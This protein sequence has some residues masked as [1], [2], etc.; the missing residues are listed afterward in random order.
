[1]F[2]VAHKDIYRVS[3]TVKCQN[4]IIFLVN[5]NK[6]HPR[7]FFPHHVFHLDPSKTLGGDRV[8]R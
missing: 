3:K 1:M 5:K 7:F 8:F 6:R 4:I 2:Y